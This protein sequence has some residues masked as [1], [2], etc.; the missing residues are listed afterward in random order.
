MTVETQNPPQKKVFR[1]S[2]FRV[3]KARKTG[4]GSASSWSL[5]GKDGLSL[6]LEMAR[7]N[8]ELDSNNNAT[9]DWKKFDKDTNTFSGGAISAKLG[10]PDIGEILLVLN[11]VKKAVGH[12]GKGLFHKNAN[13]STTINFSTWEKDNQVLGFNVRVASKSS[14]NNNEV[15]SVS[16]AL[17]L[18]EAECLR[19]L[20][21]D[22]ILQLTQWR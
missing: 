9:F 1:N 7:Q 20:L 16:H 10:L 22:S 8:G 18:G 14:L 17:T 12:E 4:D 13:G 21:N 3:Y 15:V 2:S 11:G 5:G 19:V 6:Y